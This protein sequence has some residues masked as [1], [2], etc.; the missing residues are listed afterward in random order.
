MI[1]MAEYAKRRKELMQNVGP[2]SVVILTA[3]P[4][5]M[6]NHYH[7][8]AYRQNSDFYYLSG[9]KEPEAVLILL[10]KRKEGEFILFNRV[11]NRAE[12]IWT[13]YRAGQAGACEIYG[14][15]ESF[16]I[17]DLPKYLPMLLEG[18]EKIHYTLGVDQR[19]DSLVINAYNEV[20][21]KVRGGVQAPTAFIDI[22]P[23][24]HEMRLIKSPAEIDLM[25][26]AGQITVKGHIRAMQFCKPG[27]NEYQ[28]EAELLYEFQKNG[29]R[30]CAYTPIVGGGKNSCILHYVD[31][32][33]EIKNGEIVLID[34]GCEYE[35]Y[36]SD[37]TRTFPANGKFSGE[38]RAIYE[39]VLEAQLAGI[40]LC[41]PNMSWTEI[42]TKTTHVLTQ[43][44]V[45]VG[46]LKGNVDNLVEQKAFLPF[47]MHR[48]GHF[49]GLD[50]H[51]AGR[52]KVGEKWRKL[53][54][55]MVRTIEPGLYIS[56][57]TG[58][59]KR[60]HNIGVRIEDDVLVTEN[61]NEILNDGL[62]KTVSEIE[63]IMSKK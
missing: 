1:K 20:R 28:L 48:V 41:K 40:K 44:L 19:Y 9:F 59:D 21:G 55:G 27:M 17:E 43:G 25:R 14:A 45:D 38:Q 13:G 4:A 16:P 63:N 31:N 22:R 58:V 56:A 2:D 11:R 50:T 57:D 8:Y 39:I 62:P 26:K 34:A 33:S 36:A 60:W 15:D 29:G 52:Y 53:A 18:R 12:E 54:P 32:E 61:G 49:L 5:V 35:Y 47:Y 46:I 3:A 6:R 42:E 51:D 24:L 7:E 23:T 30:F 37:V 10:P